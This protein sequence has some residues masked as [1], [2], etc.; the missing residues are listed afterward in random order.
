MTERRDSW[1]R[2]GRMK[3]PRRDGTEQPLP[4]G[5]L[6]FLWLAIVAGILVYVAWRVLATL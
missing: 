4:K 1:R 3:E 6:V 2:G 5:E